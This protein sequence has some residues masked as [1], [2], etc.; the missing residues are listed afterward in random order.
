KDDILTNTSHELRTPLNGII[1]ISESMLL[2]ATSDLSEE[3]KDNLQ[4]VVNCGLRL[5]HLVD[6]ILDLHKLKSN[7]IQLHTQAIDIRSAV[8]VTLAMSKP[9]VKDKEILLLNQVPSNLPPVEADDERLQQIL[10]NLIGN[11]IKFT[12]SGSVKVT[13]TLNNAFIKIRVIDSG[14]G[15][16]PNRQT[17]IFESFRQLD[18]STTREYGGS[19]L[20]L[21][22]TKRLVELHAGTISVTS[23]INQGATFTFSLPVSPTSLQ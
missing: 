17:V 15:I 20:G 4:L 6:D 13:A 18:S 2:G 10:F 14:I 9:L 23:E 11:A 1:G 7:A 19:G 5:S 12:P 21:S 16:P 3:A 22:I 8:D